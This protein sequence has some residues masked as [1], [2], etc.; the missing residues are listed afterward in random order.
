M[1]TY[2]HTYIRELIYEKKYRG[3]IRC[4]EKDMYSLYI[5]VYGFHQLNALFVGVGLQSFMSKLYSFSLLSN[6]NII[7]EAVRVFLS[8]FY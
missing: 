1:N 8:K 5:L 2:I 3:N 7:S 6:T 4:R